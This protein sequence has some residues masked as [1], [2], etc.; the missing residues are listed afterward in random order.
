M[1]S[2]ANKAQENKSQSVA[3]AVSQKQSGGA[4]TFHF[5]DNRTEAIAQ[6]KL[7]DMVDNSPRALQLKAFQEMSDKQMKTKQPPVQQII[8][9]RFYDPLPDGG[10]RWNILLDE[11]ETLHGSKPL[12]N[13]DDI[14]E[15]IT[16]AEGEW[17]GTDDHSASTI[18]FNA[19]ITLKS[20]VKTGLRAGKIDTN[21]ARNVGW[22]AIL[23]IIR[24]IK[25][26]GYCAVNISENVPY[27]GS[28]GV[29]WRVDDGQ[30]NDQ[31]GGWK[32]NAMNQGNLRGALGQVRT[33]IG[34][35]NDAIDRQISRD[36]WS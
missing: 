11:I 27:D 20:K 7:Q 32:Y 31:R 29:T 4:S 19:F 12:P 25:A 24:R 34:Y 9:A 26:A 36:T 35:H 23:P 6:R 5:E 30:G 1:N 16:T 2:H 17:H 28:N 15:F 10:E 22:D 18:Q 21:D 13:K 3:N 8:Q 33:A 14:D